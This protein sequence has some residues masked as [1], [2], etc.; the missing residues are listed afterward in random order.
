M[1]GCIWKKNVCTPLWAEERKVIIIEKKYP[2]NVKDEKV[3]CTRLLL[4]TRFVLCAHA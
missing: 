3:K 4:R 1:M 2:M